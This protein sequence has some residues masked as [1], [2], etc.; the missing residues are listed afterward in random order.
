MVVA[1]F[2]NH[3]KAVH[4]L[5]SDNLQVSLQTPSKE[6]AIKTERGSDTPEEEPTPAVAWLVFAQETAAS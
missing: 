4:Q 3:R 6:Q 5:N 1:R 2:D